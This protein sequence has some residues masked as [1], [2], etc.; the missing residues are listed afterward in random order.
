MVQMGCSIPTRPAFISAFCPLD[1]PAGNYVKSFGYPFGLHKKSCEKPLCAKSSSDHG[2]LKYIKHFNRPVKH[3]ETR[4][5]MGNGSTLGPPGAR[6]SSLA[7]A[8]VLI[9]GIATANSFLPLGEPWPTKVG[10]LWEG[11]SFR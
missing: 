9:T 7:L 2:V 10:H 11:C 8:V 4:E 3:V 6:F 1:A 5:T